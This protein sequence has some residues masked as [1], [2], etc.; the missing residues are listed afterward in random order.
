MQP[1]HH[2]GS[3]ASAAF[4]QSHISWQHPVRDWREDM[5][6]RGPSKY[7]GLQ[8]QVYTLVPFK[9]RAGILYHT[10]VRSWRQE[11]G[12]ML[13][14]DRSMRWNSA[15]IFLLGDQRKL[16]PIF[17]GSEVKQKTHEWPSTCL[18]LLL[19][20]PVSTARHWPSQGLRFIIWTKRN[21]T[22]LVYSIT[23]MVL[24]S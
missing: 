8:I 13:Q 16:C 4:Y 20:S 1:Y 6:W 21:T 19:P 7:Q 24:S 22:V 17:E 15:H 18:L 9:W 14:S 2:L 10:C 3:V 23:I 12:V 5:P 11:S